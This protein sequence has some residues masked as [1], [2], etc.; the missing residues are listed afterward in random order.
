MDIFKVLTM[1]SGLCLFLFG[2]NLMGQA[3]ERRAGG[4]LRTLL[5][6]MTSNVF[7]GFLTG[8]GIT[9]I[10]QSSS[11]TTVMVVGFV[12]S[13]LMTLRQ[14]INVIMGANVGTTVTA[15]LLSLAGID[16]GN[17]W[18]KLLKPTSFTPVLA[19]IGIIFYM[20]CKDAK[21]KDTGMILLGFA[22]LMFGM[23]TMSG[24]VAGLKDVPGFAELFIMFKN[25]ILGVLVGAVLTG[26]IQSSSASVGILQAL[27]LTGQVS[28]AA[29]IPI[30]MGQ[31][32]GTT[33]TAL[34]SSVGTNKNA[35]RAAVVHLMFNVIGV[36]VL[37]TVFCIVKAIF[38][39]AILNE[40][41]TMYGIAIA[42]SLFNILCTAMLLPAGNLLEKLA[43]RMVPDAAHKEEAAVELDER[44]LATPSLALRQCRAV[45]NDMAECAVRALENA[46]AAFTHY[47]PAL[48]DSIRADEDRCDHYE[49]V[50]GTYLVKLSAQKMGEAESEEA[51]ELLK[52][53]GDLERISD[54][55][56]NVLESADELQAKGLSFSG[57]AR[58]ELITL[59]DAIRE[60]LSLAE[61]A[62][63]H[64]N[65]E[66]AMKV[67]PLEQVI[68]T[69][70]E[71]MRT[72]HI[73]RM[74][75][76]QCSIEA[77]FVWS[78]LLTDLERTSDHCSNIA[79]CVIDA[80]QHNLSLHETLHAI[81]QND[82]SFQRRFRSYLETYS[83]PT[84]PSM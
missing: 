24:A 57:S 35:K 2:M 31:N 44:L 5:D 9:A 41:A 66:A 20:F 54:H 48:A 21:K 36:V 82:D 26:I 4:K 69:L 11:A 43:I 59:S 15:W 79:G 67:E 1:I 18:I 45:A 23:D 71:E 80:A 51:T 65:V 78:D 6:K 40:S 34:L 42:H 76:G 16:S 22:T 84:L 46:L 56:V 37:L 62:F 13:G 61:T 17:V 8:L 38:A 68:D 29:A 30:I 33:V 60:I 14:A 58:A 77:G 10:I 7:A 50:I 64:Q 75:Q 27:A 25:P 53:I 52:T 47:T 3:L 32:I 74:Q 55:A 83:L 12:N 39:P 70:K 28:Y 19:L 63:L 49:D 81:R 73:L 72:R